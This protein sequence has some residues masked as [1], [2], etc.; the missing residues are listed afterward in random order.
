MELCKKYF[1]LGW[2]FLPFLWGVNA[3]WFYKE[4]FRKPEFEGQKTIKKLVIMSGI[5][6]LVWLVGLITWITI[7]TINR[8]EWGATADYM[9]FNIPLGKP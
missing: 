7:F 4:A 3:V 5:G 1:Y 2:A 6:A 8:A 9:S